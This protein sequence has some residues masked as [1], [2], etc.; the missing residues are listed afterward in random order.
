MRSFN[1][2]G[3]SD[4]SNIY[5]IKTQ[6]AKD[7]L[8]APTESPPPNSPP[9]S[10]PEWPYPPETMLI[11]VG[12]LTSSILVVCLVVCVIRC[13]GQAP[14]PK[15]IKKGKVLKP[16]TPGDY[17]FNSTNV[18]DRRPNGQ[19]SVAMTAAQTS[20]N[21]SLKPPPQPP[22][23]VHQETAET[24]NS[25]KQLTT[26]PLNGTFNEMS[27]LNRKN[28]F[29]NSLSHSTHHLF[30]TTANGKVFDGYS[31]ATAVSTSVVSTATIDRKRMIKSS[32]AEKQP[33]YLEY[34]PRAMNQHSASFTRLNG[35]LERKRK[36]RT[37]LNTIDRSYLRNLSAAGTAISEMD[38]QSNGN[39]AFLGP[40]NG[41]IVIMQS[42]C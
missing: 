16:S 40:A 17:Y 23:S 1:P 34:P 32:I 42:S 4:F 21:N 27:S 36:S 14:A 12:A 11:L 20:R 6:P 15:V 18:Y 7:S 29:R 31:T 22:P 24:E 9:S 5:T 35:T 19:L 28:S 26:R 13:K 30:N 37:D 3:T 10:K 39:A 2:S 41:P 38:R 8:P 25:G 33:A